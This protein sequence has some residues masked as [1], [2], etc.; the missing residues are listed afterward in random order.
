MP[1]KP[2]SISDV[3]LYALCSCALK[4]PAIADGIFSVNFGKISVRFLK[5]W[6][7]EKIMTSS[8][9]IMFVT[10]F[11]GFLFFVVHDVWNIFQENEIQT[12]AG[13][14]LPE[15]AAI[16]NSVP[17]EMLLIFK[18][19]DLLRGIETSLKSRADT[20]SFITMSR[21][22][23]RAMFDM[24][25][26]FCNTWWCSFRL[27]VHERIVLFKLS[28]YELYL[29]MNSMVNTKSKGLMSW[30]LLNLGFFICIYQSKES[31]QHQLINVQHN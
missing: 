15:I 31:N 27:H 3:T 24:K 16:L 21:C 1:L 14:Y 29:W 23:V 17:R 19:N 7:F 4:T 11:T 18:T 26:K 6:G 12:S 9:N 28:L 2:E 13:N 10:Q 8:F 30:C 5:K 22:C 25:R 20:Q